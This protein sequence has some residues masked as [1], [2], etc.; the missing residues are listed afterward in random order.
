V[1]ARTILRACATVVA[2]QVSHSRAA[3]LCF[4]VFFD[5]FS[6]MLQAHVSSVLVVS[7]IC[8][9]FFMRMLQK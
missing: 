4:Q 9:N 8:F 2:H 5:A 6:D 7:D 3:M 1:W